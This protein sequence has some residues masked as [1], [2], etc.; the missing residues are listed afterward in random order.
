MNMYNDSII[1]GTLWM[2]NLLSPDPSNSQV[3]NLFDNAQI[4]MADIDGTLAATIQRY[5]DNGWVNGLV[6]WNGIDTTIVS[7]V[8]EPATMILLGFGSLALIRRKR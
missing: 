6:S 8:P 2:R 4:I 7:A 3:I 5:I 1:N